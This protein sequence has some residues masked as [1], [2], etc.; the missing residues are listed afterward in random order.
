MFAVTSPTAPVTQPTVAQIMSEWSLSELASYIRRLTNSVTQENLDK[1]L[2][3]V[4]TIRDKTSLNTRVDAQ[5]LCRSFR[6][7]I[8]MQ[9]SL[10]LTLASRSQL[11]RHLLDR[12]T[13]GVIIVYPPRDPL[14]E[15]DEGCEF[16]IFYEKRLAQDLINDDE[17]SE[18][19]EYRGVDAEDASEAK[20]QMVPMAQTGEWL[21]LDEVKPL[22]PQALHEPVITNLLPRLVIMPTSSTMNTTLMFLRPSMIRNSPDSFDLIRRNLPHL[23]RPENMNRLHRL[24]LILEESHPVLRRRPRVLNVSLVITLPSGLWKRNVALGS[25]MLSKRSH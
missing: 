12:I 4:A 25:M 19:F 15:S 2:E 14:P 11:Y 9:T 7:I 10:Q 22:H 20:R 8:A 5:P 13:E 18:Y 1:T 17:W 16:A 3:M 23:S 6:R 24:E 21:F